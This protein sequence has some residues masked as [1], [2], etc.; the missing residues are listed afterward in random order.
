MYIKIEG[1]EYIIKMYF[2]IFQGYVEG[3]QLFVWHRASVFSGTVLDAH[4]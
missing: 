3:L 4:N 2:P 1:R